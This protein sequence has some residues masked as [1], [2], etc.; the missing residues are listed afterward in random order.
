MGP[1]LQTSEA[2]CSSQFVGPARVLP[3]RHA[4][5][6]TSN[7]IPPYYSFFLLLFDKFYMDIYVWGAY[8]P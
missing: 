1:I 4:E 6:N 3:I 8:A 7:T 5:A 2:E